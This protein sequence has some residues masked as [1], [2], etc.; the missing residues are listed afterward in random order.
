[1]IDN[2]GSDHAIAGSKMGRKSAGNAEADDAAAAG[3]LCD[4]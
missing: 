3:A 4:L 1:M 2:G